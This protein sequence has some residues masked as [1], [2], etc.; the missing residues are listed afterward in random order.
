MDGRAAFSRA[1]RSFASRVCASLVRAAGMEDL[2]CPT[3][4]SI[5]ERAIEFGTIAERPSRPCRSGSR[6]ARHLPAVRYADADAAPGGP[7]SPDV[8]GVRGRRL[9]VPDLTNLDVY[10]DLG[11]QLNLEHVGTLQDEEYRRRYQEKLSLQ[12]Q[13]YPIQP[14]ARIWRGA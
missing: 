12:H 9:P 7:L 11:V 14:D 4:E 13:T 8:G 10:C 5:P 6:P 3:L 1:G 2:I